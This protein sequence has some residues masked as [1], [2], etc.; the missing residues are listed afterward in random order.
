MHTQY[1]PL[2][3]HSHRQPTN[4][5]EHVSQRA[6]NTWGTY[7]NISSEKIFIMAQMTTGNWRE[8]FEKNFFFT[9]K[10]KMEGIKSHFQHPKNYRLLSS[11]YIKEDTRATWRKRC[12]CMEGLNTRWD[13]WSFSAAGLPTMKNAPFP[14]FKPKWAKVQSKPPGG[15]GTR[16]VG[17]KSHL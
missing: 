5:Q 2:W 14:S 4:K 13:T 1:W 9:L 15:C 12:T 7:T 10:R 8:P 6:V 17:A 3:T 16:Q 11:K